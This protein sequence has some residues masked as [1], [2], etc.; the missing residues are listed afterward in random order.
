MDGYTTS[1]A[2]KILWQSIV[3]PRQENF[4]THLGDHDWILSGSA[5][6]WTL[7]TLKSIAKQEYCRFYYP[8]QSVA[9][10]Y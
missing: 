8:S 6:K 4:I 3:V 7:P 10:L 1:N 2:R 9:F 5:V